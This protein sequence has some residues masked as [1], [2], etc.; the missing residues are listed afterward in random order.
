MTMQ[1]QAPI[2]ILRLEQVCSIISLSRSAVYDRL[3]PKSP[4]HDRSF[5]KQ[6]PLGG[7]AVGFLASEVNAWLQARM[8]AR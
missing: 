7:R 6:I 2:Q 8:D 3:D 5:P 1:N 4:R